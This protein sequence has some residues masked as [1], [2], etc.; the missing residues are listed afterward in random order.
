MMTTDLLVAPVS[1]DLAALLIRLAICVALLPY[2]I[3]KFLTRRESSQHFP[4]VMFFSPHT[5]FYL[6][7]C[8]ETFAPLFIIIGLF[9]RL[10]AIAG[11]V[12]MGV[13]FTVSKDKYLASPASAYFLGFI[14]I[15][16]I[17]PGKYS[18]DWFCF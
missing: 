18:L 10:A 11:I 16:I 9:T 2:G 12:N 14:A 3:K 4:G 1:Y 8:V 15:L 7:M 6:A 5:A 17:G 13:A